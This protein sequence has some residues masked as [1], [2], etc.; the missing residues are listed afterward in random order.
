MTVFSFCWNCIKTLLIQPWQCCV[1][2]LYYTVI[3][4]FIFISDGFRVASQYKT[5]LA[6]FVFP[7][8]LTYWW[9]KLISNES[10][11]HSQLNSILLHY[12]FYSSLYS[13]VWNVGDS[14]MNADGHFFFFCLLLSVLPTSPVHHQVRCDFPLFKCDVGVESWP[15]DLRPTH[16]PT[17]CFFFV[18]ET[19]VSSI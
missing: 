15:S 4:A 9:N 13:F 17:C 3:I 5:A 19:R 18:C 1:T 12:T 7:L 8:L 2:V 6:S 16:Y 14:F 11:K 10:T